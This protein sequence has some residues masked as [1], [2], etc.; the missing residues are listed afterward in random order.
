MYKVSCFT[1]KEGEK[2]KVIE[3][4]AE[5]YPKKLLNIYDIPKKLYVIGNE[6]ILNDFGIA[7]VGTRNASK[8]GQEITKSLA[9]GLAKQGVCI[10]SGLARGIDTAA[11]TGALM[12]K[13]KTTAVLGSG[14]GNIY[15][16]ENTELILNII[17]HG[18]A[19]ITEY[20]VNEKPLP[21]NFPRRNR[22]ISGLSEGVVVTEAGE[23]SGS[24]ITADIALEQGKEV[25]AVP[26]K[27]TIE[28]FKRYKCTNKTRCKTYR[29]YI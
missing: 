15:P 19:I 17:N 11:H 3:I 25:F 7:I 12:A 24:L 14:F 20:N 22:I 4:G 23:R 18:G 6:K 13:G 29:E 16:R 1:L 5:S 27:C 2:M 10:I 8:Y 26:R 9:Y 21:Q 28:N